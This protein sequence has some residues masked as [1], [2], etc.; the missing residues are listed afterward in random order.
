MTPGEPVVL[1]ISPL[2][3]VLLMYGPEGLVLGSLL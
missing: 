1:V 3:L 2:S